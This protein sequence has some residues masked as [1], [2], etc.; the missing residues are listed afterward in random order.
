[1]KTSAKFFLTQTGFT[2]LEV[3][4]SLVIISLSGAMLLTFYNTQVGGSEQPVTLMEQGLAL[5]TTLEKITADYTYLLENDATPLLTLETRINASPSSYG[6]YSA[7]TKFITF[8]GSGNEESAACTADCTSLKVT[9][10]MGN[11]S[12]TTLFTKTP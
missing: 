12:L 3:I 10:T 6:V 9:I 11:Q 4:V 8:D 5:E 2:L 7:V 1:M